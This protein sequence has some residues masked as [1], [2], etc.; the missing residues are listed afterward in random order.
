M[1][2]DEYEVT[3]ITRNSAEVGC[4]EVTRE[5]VVELLKAMDAAP[6]AEVK[7]VNVRPSTKHENVFVVEVNGEPVVQIWPGN[8]I[9]L[10]GSAT[11]KSY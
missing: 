4:T 3:N 6:V 10:R 7:S 9:R 2:I 5:Q 1:Y 11:L 8:K